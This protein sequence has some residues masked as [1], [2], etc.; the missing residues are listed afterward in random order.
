MKVVFATILAFAIVLA[1]PADIAAKDSDHPTIDTNAAD[2]LGLG[3]SKDYVV[4]TIQ[5]LRKYPGRIKKTRWEFKK[6]TLFVL[7]IGRDND[8]I[9]TDTC[10]FINKN[11]IQGPIKIEFID[12]IELY[13]FE[14]ILR[15]ESTLCEG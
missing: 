9:I 14:K 13:Y 15:Y 7:H 10:K 1:E 2:S 3:I 4:A 8:D 11:N 12:F 5:L 6:I